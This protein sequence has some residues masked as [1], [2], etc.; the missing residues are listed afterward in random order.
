MNRSHRPAW[1]APTLPIACALLASVVSCNQVST[2]AFEATADFEATAATTYV[3]QVEYNPR[4][5]NQDRPNDRRLEQFESTTVVNVNGIR[6]EAAGSG[7]D[8]KGLWWPV[9]PPEPTVDDIEDRRKRAEIPRS[10]EVIK[11]VDYNITFNQSGEAKTLPTNN[12][13]YR[14]AVKAFEADRPLA[15][16]LGPQDASVLTAEIQ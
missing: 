9:L 6:P 14:Q 4:N 13:V 10:P 7:P 1:F 15:L 5:A 12:D 3:W 2:N 8:S 11:K 16:T